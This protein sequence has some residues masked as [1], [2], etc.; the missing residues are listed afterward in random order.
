M[1]LRSTAVHYSLAHYHKRLQ[2]PSGKS[3][4]SVGYPHCQNSI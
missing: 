1:E 3:V 4:S 2:E